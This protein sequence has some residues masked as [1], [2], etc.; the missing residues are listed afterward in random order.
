MHNI[1][2]NVAKHLKN[3]ITVQDSELRKCETKN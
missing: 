2:S 1:L 3:N